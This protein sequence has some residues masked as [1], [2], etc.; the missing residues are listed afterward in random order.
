MG[1]FVWARYP[2]TDQPATDAGLPTFDWP[3]MFVIVLIAGSER[4]CRILQ[5]GKR[6]DH[7]AQAKK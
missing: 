6:T 1:V 4:T 5:M 2:C 7:P 3:C